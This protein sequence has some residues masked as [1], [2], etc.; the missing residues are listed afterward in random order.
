MNLKNSAIIGMLLLVGCTG[1]SQATPDGDAS[2]ASSA[3]L[4]E[5]TSHN[6]LVT[7]VTSSAMSSVAA[8]SSSAVSKET[9][10]KFLLPVPFA[11]QA[12]FGVWDAV[13]K[14]ACEE[15][16]LIMVHHFLEGTSVTPEQAEEE[17]QALVAWETKNGY[18]IDVN[19][20]QE[21]RIARDYY[22]YRARVETDPSAERLR[23]LLIAGHPVIVPMAGRML[24][25]PYFTGDG[26]WY[27]MLVLRGYEKSWLGDYFITNDPGTRRG[28]EYRYRETVV[29]DSMHDW[30]G[31]NERIAEGAKRIIV[32]EK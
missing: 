22:G 13:H 12:P 8:A 16:S 28:E 29:M 14:E 11:G 17:I 4:E 18:G 25:N 9:P 27:H 15:A 6:A 24:G 10:S 3:V 1:Q 20:E 19:A 31:V 5:K 32:V 30:V 23:E 7:D 2:S 26:P 21:A